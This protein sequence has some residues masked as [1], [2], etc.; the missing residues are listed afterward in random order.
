MLWVMDPVRSLACAL[1][2]LTAIA[3][4]ATA[5][6][7][8]EALRLGVSERLVETGLLKYVLPRF[9]LKTGVRIELVD[10]G[11]HAHMA[12]AAGGGGRAVFTGHGQT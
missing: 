10:E 3:G 1:V 12:L 5:A 9:S 7:A 8:A 6:S 4:A 2:L 11:A